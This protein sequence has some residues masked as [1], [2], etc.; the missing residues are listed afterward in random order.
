[1]RKVLIM[2]VICLTGVFLNIVITRFCINSAEIPLFLDTIFTITVTL[3]CGLI[4]GIVCGALTNILCHSIFGWGWE[5]Y[6]FTLCNI[7]TA[8]ITWFFRNELT[9]QEQSLQRRSFMFKTS[10]LN[11][12][13]NKVII[14]IIFSFA[15][16]LAMSILGGI[17]ASFILY[18]NT[19]YT[20]GS[21]ISGIL[22][23][24][25]FG[26]DVPVVFKEIIS[27]LPINI[28]DRLIS[29]FTGYGIFLL[30]RRL[31]KPTALENSLSV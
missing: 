15:L 14:L 18:I 3:N 28:A 8:V 27:R 16:C 11:R 7:A 23:T 6:L 24:T 13:M 12:I 22:S 4:W 9:G 30:L 17:I 21:G 25:M 31:L 10:Q 29:A 20:E 1:M 26:H 5:P 2:P 19:S